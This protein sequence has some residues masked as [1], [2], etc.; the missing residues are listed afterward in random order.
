MLVLWAAFW[1]LAGGLCVE[2][3]ELHARI[4]RA[5]KWSWRRPIPQGR[6]AYWTSVAIRAGV[7]AVLAAAAAASGQVTGAFG[8]L[9]LGVAAPLVVEKF[10]RLATLAAEA[11]PQAIAQREAPADAS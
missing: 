6:A 10:A 1:G 7:G 9:G 8:A 2:A 11:E 3:L 5:R 4:R